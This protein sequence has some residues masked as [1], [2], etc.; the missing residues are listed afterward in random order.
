ML[1]PGDRL[2]TFRRPYLVFPVE[3]S[4]TSVSPDP[5]VPGRF[6][7]HLEL[8]EN[9]DEIDLGMFRMVDLTGVY[10]P[11]RTTTSGGSEYVEI[12]HDDPRFNC[13]LY[14][15]REYNLQLCLQQSALFVSKARH[16]CKCILQELRSLGA[17]PPAELLEIMRR[18]ALE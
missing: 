16:G 10:T 12:S 5:E 9:L 8:K 4:V 6:I 11:G 2:Y 1:K 15:D 14:L 13:Y 7:V 3:G 18:F 17:E